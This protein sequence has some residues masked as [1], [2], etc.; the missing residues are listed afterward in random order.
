MKISIAVY[1]HFAFNGAL[2]ALNSHFGNI[3]HYVAWFMVT[4]APTQPSLHAACR[5]HVCGVVAS[6]PMCAAAF[7]DGDRAGPIRHDLYMLVRT[8]SSPGHDAIQEQHNS[9][10][11]E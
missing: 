4:P 7:E 8:S 6:C 3:A 9:C 1:F 5:K 11:R 2:Q 10:N